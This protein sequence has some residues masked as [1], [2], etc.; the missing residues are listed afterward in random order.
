MTLAD[1]VEQLAGERDYL[2][3]IATAMDWR[4]S[5]RSTVEARRDALD[6]VL[7]LLEKVSR[8]AYA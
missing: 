8:D 7:V 1:V 3:D 4:W 6:H 5:A 2:D